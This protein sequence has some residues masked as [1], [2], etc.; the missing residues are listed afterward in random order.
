VLG[1]AMGCVAVLVLALL[2]SVGRLLRR[3]RFLSPA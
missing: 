1:S 2:G 3:E